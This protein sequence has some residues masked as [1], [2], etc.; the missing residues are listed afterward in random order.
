MPAIS[1]LFKR[2]H[3]GTTDSIAPTQQNNL[4][5]WFSLISFFLISL[6]AFGLG[7]VSTQFLVSESLERDAL[8]SAQFIQT[9]A[10]GEI[11]H[12]GLAGMRMGDVLAATQYGMLSEE[13]S[14]NRHRA[15][16]EFLDHLRTYRTHS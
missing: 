9:I 5:H 12:H 1:V 2:L 13:M 4:L 7:T 11:R 14:L 8:L 3:R 6:I 16:S 10:Q 15:R